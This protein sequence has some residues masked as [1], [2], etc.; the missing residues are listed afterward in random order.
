ML[1]EQHAEEKAIDLILDVATKY[2]FECRLPGQWG[3]HSRYSLRGKA[4]GGPVSS[5]VLRTR[6]REDERRRVR[7]RLAGAA[8]AAK[9]AAGSANAEAK[10]PGADALE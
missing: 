2:I 3:L 8:A 4:V 9:T 10:E 1:Q 7:K 5:K 6:E